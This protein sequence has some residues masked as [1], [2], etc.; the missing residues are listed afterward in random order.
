MDFRM[1]LMI[2]VYI[3][4]A[5]LT[6]SWK[7]ERKERRKDVPDERMKIRRIEA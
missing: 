1:C 3:H 2:V 6:Y 5:L 4:D 7:E